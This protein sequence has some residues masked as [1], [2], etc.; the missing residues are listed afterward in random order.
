MAKDIFHELVK[1]A[2]IKD[3]WTITHDPLNLEHLEQKLEIDL[4]A[5]IMLAAEKESFKIAVE[6]KS[7][8]SHSRIYDF[9]LALGQYRNY[10][11]LLQKLETKRTLF[12]AVPMD[13]YTDFFLEAYGQEAIKEESLKI[14]VF[15]IDLKTIELWIN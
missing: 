12:L 13:A 5:E 11:R 1:N 14:I 9:H 3:G 8:L 6:I 2:L 4:G 15:D 10:Y 7:F